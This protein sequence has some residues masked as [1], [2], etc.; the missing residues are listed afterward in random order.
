MSEMLTEPVL[1]EAD[2]AFF[3]ANG[4]VVVKKAAPPE[5]LQAVVNAIFEYLQMDANNPDDWYRPPL[6][7]GGMIEMYQHQALW[8]NR[9][10]PRIHRAFADLFGTE[11]LWVSIDRANLKPPFRADHPEYDHKGFMHWDTDVTQADTAPFGV[12]GVLYLTDTTENMGG[13]QCSPGHHKIVREWA[14]GVEA[15][16]GAK[17]DMTGVPVVPIAGEAGDLVIWDRNLYHGNGHN[18]SDKPRLAQ[19]ITMF[20]VGTGGGFEMRREDRVM[21]W[22]ERL[23]PDAKWVGKDDRNFEQRH[24]TT[25]ELTPLGRK[26]L[27]IDSWD[28]SE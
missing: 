10:Y 2:K 7:H 24:G 17:P 18:L 15:G 13:F 21:R 14:K 23:P 28:T 6:T 4:Y 8:N 11:K 19:Y 12:Q 1:T 9:Q 25:A 27:G 20:P 5:N 16:S 3:D 26:L 22:R